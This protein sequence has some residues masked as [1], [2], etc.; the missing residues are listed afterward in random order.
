[1]KLPKSVKAALWSY[2]TLAIDPIVDR[3]L[4]ITNVLNVGTKEAVQWLFQQ[5]NKD[6]MK[7]V[8]GS[9]KPGVWNKRSLNLWSL[10][11][12]VPAKAHSRF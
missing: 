7:A 6:E 11:F 12:Q 3:E 1:M 8:V 10:V 2:D 9:P 5:Y 4:I